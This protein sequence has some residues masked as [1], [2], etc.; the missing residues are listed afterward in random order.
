MRRAERL[1]N[2]PNLLALLKNY[3]EQPYYD[4]G[5]L[6]GWNGHVKCIYCDAAFW[7]EERLTSSSRNNPRFGKCCNHGMI[8]LALPIE[9]LPDPLYDILYTNTRAARKARAN[10]RSYNMMCCMVS[11]GIK[12][13][14]PKGPPGNIR[15]NG[16]VFHRSGPL[17]PANDRPPKFMQVFTSDSAVTDT[18]TDE[19]LK[20]LDKGLLKALRD[21]LKGFNPY[22]QL[23]MLASA[24]GTGLD[25]NGEQYDLEP[26]MDLHMVFPRNV[27]PDIDRHVL[28]TPA[29]GEVG[30]ILV[31]DIG[32]DTRDII[33][34]RNVPSGQKV[35]RRIDDL[36]PNYMPMAYPLLLPYGF[37]GYHLDMKDQDYKK[38]TPLDFFRHLMQVRRA[39]N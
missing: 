27:G 5:H 3:E 16:Q 10:L 33:I 9:P 7:M 23:G 12:D 22:V 24:G 26:G 19:I 15:V 4:V 29:L 13:S 1:L 18:S 6:G 2:P 37:L 36:N 38:I 35:L 30:M 20:S 11:S 32:I 14:C 8:N 34:S 25:A 28:G 39:P 21:M 31:G 17:G